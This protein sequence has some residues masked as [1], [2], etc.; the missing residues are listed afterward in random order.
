[1]LEIYRTLVRM[2]YLDASWICEGPHDIE[3]LVPTYHSY[4]LDDAVIY[5]YSILPY[6]GTAGATYLDFFQGGEFA[7]F[8]KEEDV[9]Q[10]R[11]PFY[12]GDEDSQLPPYMTTL[13]S[14]LSNHRSVIFWTTSPK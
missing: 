6:V 12:E 3:A 10:G 7:D 14:L 4:G 1:M 11:G 8:R 13:S 2:R 9:K 5:L